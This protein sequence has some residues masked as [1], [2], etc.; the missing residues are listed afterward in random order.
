MGSG[1]LLDWG[2]IADLRPE[3]MSQLWEHIVLTVI[4][5]TVGFLISFPL[6]VYAHRHK[7][8]YPPITFVT[9][10][11]YT[12]PSI[13]LFL[14]LQ[15]ITGYFS[16]TT[17]EIGLV[18]YTLLI[19]IRNTVSGLREVPADTKE[20]ALGMGFSRRQLLWRVE[21]PLALPVIMA[22]IR[23]ATVTT[24]GLVTV[25]ALIGKGGLGLFILKGFNFFDSTQILV[26]AVLSMVLAMVADALLVVSERR[27]TPWA[28]RRG[29]KAFS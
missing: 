21:V 20:A 19:L 12:I 4:A 23:L 26:G 16:T 28:R 7:R 27:V 2:R 29:V 9:G 22:G 8:F 13:A 5:V 18:G 11:L 17:A 3:I 6:A 15:P 14:F 25:T 10:L 24:I 1:T